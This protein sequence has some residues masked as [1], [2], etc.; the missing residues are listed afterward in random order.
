MK[1]NLIESFFENKFE[2][3][4]FP[5]YRSN[6]ANGATNLLGYYPK[7]GVVDEKRRAQLQ[8]VKEKY[9]KNDIEEMHDVNFKALTNFYTDASFY[10]ASD[11][12]AR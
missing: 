11:K 1:A 9:F 8:L 5:N 10:Y 12:L 4:V 3:I 7:D 2:L 6:D